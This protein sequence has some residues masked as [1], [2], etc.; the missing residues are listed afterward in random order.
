MG[1]SFQE[2]VSCQRLGRR[3]SEQL[4]T[5]TRLFPEPSLQAIALSKALG[6]LCGLRWLV[7]SNVSALI[8]KEE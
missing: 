7:L 4:E 5:D 8:F 1:T 3:L 6:V 2:L